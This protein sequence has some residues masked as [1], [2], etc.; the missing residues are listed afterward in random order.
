M[1]PYQLIGFTLAAVAV[2]GGG[3]FIGL[4]L[5]AGSPEK[6]ERKRRLMIHQQG[7]LGDA[8]ITEADGNTVFFEYSIHGVHY[9]T[10]QDVSALRHLLPGVPEQL[11]G[12]A[13]MKYLTRNPANSI[14]VC[15]EWNGLRSLPRT[16]IRSLTA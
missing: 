4:R 16:P 8:F 3:L 1:N 7:R 12:V 5:A 11:I 14:L 6:R 15:E 2:I 13:N 10:S 9:S